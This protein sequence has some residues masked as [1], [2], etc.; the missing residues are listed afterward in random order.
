[1]RVE[2]WWEVVVRELRVALTVEL[3]V[4]N[5]VVVE[6]E[7]EVRGIGETMMVMVL[8]MEG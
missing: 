5:E 1:V 2:W 7:D 6:I 8:E 4:L 3:S